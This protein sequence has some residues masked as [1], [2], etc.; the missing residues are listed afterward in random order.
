MSEI[1][2]PRQLNPQVR[3]A[4]K[5]IET[6]GFGGAAATIDR[7]LLEHPNDDDLYALYLL[8]KLWKGDA[9][10]SFRLAEGRLKV[11]QTAG[12]AAFAAEAS[13]YLAREGDYIRYA[14]IAESLDPD[15]FLNLRQ[16]ANKQLLEGDPKAA[17]DFMRRSLLLYPEDAD[18]YSS[19]CNACQLTGD[20]AAGTELVEN[21]PDWFRDTPQYH[22]RL[23]MLALAK[24]DME[25]AV[26]ELRTAVAKCPEG[27]G[28]WGNLSLALRSISR[29]EEAEQAAKYGVELNSRN[30]VALSTLAIVARHRGDDRAAAEWE[31]RSENAVP[32][33]VFQKVLRKTK[34]LL[35]HKKREEAIQYLRAEIKKTN[36]PLARSGRRILIN[37]LVDAKRFS[38]ARAEWEV[39]IK[40]DDDPGL[41]V[42]E[43]QILEGEG[44]SAEASALLTRLL[45]YRPVHPELYIH[46]VNHLIKSGDDE[47]LNGFVAYLMENVPGPPTFLGGAIVALSEGGRKEQSRQL[48]SA[49]TRRYPENDAL[50]LIGGVFAAEG[51]NMRGA[52]HTFQSLPT[53]MRPTLKVNFGAI[54]RNPKFWKG[55]FRRFR[56]K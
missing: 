34:E 17:T 22:N 4:R 51:G 46:A 6:K 43:F 45:D 29:Y 13:H 12:I 37:L 1:L 50:R 40:A 28:Y 33:L 15:H 52:I 19:L 26:K 38:E 25:A 44:S 48:H 31:Q 36:S 10:E 35:R 41:R 30:S 8:L 47:G 7:L 24:R 55:L 42:A 18:A 53:D 20:L 39:A 11:R 23:G 32:A 49:A 21:C 16:Q 54:L 3:E 27:G 5:A 56:K 14:A 2:T 9:D